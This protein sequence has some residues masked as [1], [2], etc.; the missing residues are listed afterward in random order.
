MANRLRRWRDRFDFPGIV[1]LAFGVGL[2][3][4]GV[5]WGEVVDD[6]EVISHH[7]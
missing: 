6:W 5:R 3:V 1:G 4:D 2:L 7:S